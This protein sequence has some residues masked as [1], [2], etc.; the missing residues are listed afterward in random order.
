M[1]CLRLWFGDEAE[2]SLF[3]ARDRMGQKPLYI[4]GFPDLDPNSPSVSLD[5]PCVAF[6]SE[7]PTW[8]F[9]RWSWWDRTAKRRYLFVSFSRLCPPPNNFPRRAKG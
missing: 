7:L 8:R 6:A 3:L 9:S 5:G 1:G 4:A 2:K